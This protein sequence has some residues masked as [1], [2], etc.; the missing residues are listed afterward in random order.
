MHSDRRPSCHRR[1]VAASRWAKDYRVSLRSP[2]P[3]L[4]TVSALT[5]RSAVSERLRSS[6]SLM[7]PCASRRT[8]RLWAV[9]LEALEGLDGGR[10]AEMV[11]T[12]VPDGPTAQ[13]C[14]RRSLPHIRSREDARFSF[15]SRP[16][17]VNPH[18][19]NY[20]LND[21]G[22]SGHAHALRGAWIKRR[23]RQ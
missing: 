18:E 16:A 15:S 12:S 2:S 7:R 10:D 9:E 3:F 13:L 5:R 8:Y 14:Q 23:G 21:C 19:I 11:L 17:S 1:T 4:A 6:L 20:L 22:Q